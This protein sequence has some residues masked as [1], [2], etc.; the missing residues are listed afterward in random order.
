MKSVKRFVS[1]IMVLCLMLSM[2]NMN[3]DASDY[4][5]IVMSKQESKLISTKDNKYSLTVM[6]EDEIRTVKM[7]DFRNKT[8]MTCLY[9]KND[10]HAEIT[11]KDLMRRCV[12]FRFNSKSLGNSIYAQKFNGRVYCKYDYDNDK[13]WYNLKSDY[14]KVNIG[15]SSEKY[16]IAFAGDEN[17]AKKLNQYMGAINNCNSYREKA[18]S[19]CMKGG[20]SWGVAL[21]I[22]AAAAVVPEETAV[23]AAICAA[24]GLDMV[25][26]GTNAISSVRYLVKLRVE[27]Q[28]VLKYYKAAKKYA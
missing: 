11:V 4:D 10:D 1:F 17:R 7:K 18:L 2:H 23:A 24:C 5:K 22:V 19:A 16:G 14:T 21:G 12:V 27:Y 9:Y 8:E 15:T 3:V 28:S 26:V 13:H 6:D 25:A 20:I